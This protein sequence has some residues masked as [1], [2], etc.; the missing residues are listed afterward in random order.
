[1]DKPSFHIVYDMWD[2]MIEKVKMTIY[3]H[4]G[5]IIEEESTFYNVMHQILVDRW[6]KNNTPLHCMAH[7]VNPK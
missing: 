2:T 1:M 5:K 3:R 6:N 4:E 7:S